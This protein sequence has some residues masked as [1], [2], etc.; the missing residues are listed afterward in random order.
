METPTF[1]E[2]FAQLRY[3]FKLLGVPLEHDKNIRL[4][5]YVL[6]LS[7]ILVLIEEITF[8]V[9]KISSSNLL[10]LTQLAPCIGIG[11][12]SFLKVCSIAYKK[13]K[14]IKLAKYLDALYSDILADTRNKE[15]VRNE[16][17]TLKLVTKYYFILNVMLISVY[18]FSTLIFSIYH[19]I[20][21]KHFNFNLPYSVIV[22]FSTENWLNWSV[23]YIQL[24]IAGF[25]TVLFFTTVDILYCVFSCHV[26][27][28]FRILSYEIKHLEIV[29]TKTLGEFV[30]KHQHIIKLSEDLE[31]I[32]N[33]TNLFNVLVGSFEICALGFSLT[34]GYW[35]QVPGCILFMS[36][37]LLR[38]LMMCFF[39]EKIEIESTEVSRS[40]YHSEWYHMESKHKKM[41][42]IIMTRSHK[43]QKLTTYK[44]SVITYKTFT[45]IISTSWTYF[46]LLKTVYNPV[47]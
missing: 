45:R 40:A 47:E 35:S 46:T 16:M 4:K 17:L 31:D 12:L 24:I 2:V 30:K 27:N 9:N 20:V 10:E 28:N 6:V 21:Y 14:I 38:I 42:L 43:P 22:P 25:T 39:G 8:F 5:F 13:N 34:S 11:T 37:V 7:L 1:E 44:F 41:L 36:S 29:N 3:Q 19:F 23:V 26:C 32:F 15:I 18:N 33:T